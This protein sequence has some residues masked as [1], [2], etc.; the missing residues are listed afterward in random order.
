MTNLPTIIEDLTLVPVPAWWENPWVW[1]GAL[2]ALVQD[3]ETGDMLEVDTGDL[4][5][6]AAYEQA[7]AG[8]QE[9]AREFLRRSRI[10]HL[11]LRT[12]R[13]WSNPL[14]TFLTLQA[15]RR[16]A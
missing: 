5:V 6:R 1:A 16:V 8:H 7:A 3:A 2:V 13:P 11:E 12:D 4:S 10:G 9:A 14:R 15:R